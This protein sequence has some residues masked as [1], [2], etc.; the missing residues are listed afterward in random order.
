MKKA[1]AYIDKKAILAL[2]KV[3]FNMKLTSME[4]PSK[5]DRIKI[6]IEGND[7]P[8]K[9]TH[10]NAKRLP[11]IDYTV[12]PH[13]HVARILPKAKELENEGQEES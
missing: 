11:E 12:L 7:L 2:L 6:V 10:H 5:D 9:K 13:W 4:Y 1:V 8:T 3:P